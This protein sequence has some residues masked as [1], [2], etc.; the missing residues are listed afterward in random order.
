MSEGEIDI[1]AF[2]LTCTLIEYSWRVDERGKERE[3]RERKNVSEREGRC[4][5]EKERAREKRTIE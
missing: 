1:K 3:G 2:I 4:K 5:R